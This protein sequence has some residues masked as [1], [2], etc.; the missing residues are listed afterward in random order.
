M[1]V[2]ATFLDSTYGELEK[3]AQK[4]RKDGLIL[5]LRTVG[6]VVYATLG[7]T[8]KGTYQG[9]LYSVGTFDSGLA[10][11]AR[12]NQRPSAELGV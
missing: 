2:F 6:H 12:R 4:H 9:Y 8:P 1:A 10:I 5:L 7:K 11:Y 3:N